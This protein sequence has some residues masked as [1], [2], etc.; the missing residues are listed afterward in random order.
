MRA[1]RSGPPDDPVTGSRD[2]RPLFDPRSIAV[3]GA[4]DDPRKW[5]HWLALRALRG[6][7]RRAVHLV[8]R[9]GAEVLAE[10]LIRLDGS[11]HQIFDVG[12]RRPDLDD[13][14]LALTGRVAEDVQADDDEQP[15]EP[16]P[17]G[18]TR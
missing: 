4:S 16:V 17:T 15:A 3:V 13:V 11:I 1:S 18:G 14:F 12:L 6:E 5:G 9:G 7:H 8:N 10:A 2:L